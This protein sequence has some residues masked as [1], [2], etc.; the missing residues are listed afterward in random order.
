MPW[1]RIRRRRN[2]PRVFAASLGRA[3]NNL[4]W[5]TPAKGVSVISAPGTAL[6]ERA[7]AILGQERG[8]TTQ[9]MARL[10]NDAVE[11]H[12][13]VRA[14]ARALT[15]EQI[16]AE[17]ALLF[18]QRGLRSDALLASWFQPLAR[19]ADQSPV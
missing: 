18:S 4:S 17:F 3:I 8:V 6:H 15:D 5:P 16:A 19:Q 10:L 11:V 9:T 7:V 2:P 13:T 14:K 12:R 1:R